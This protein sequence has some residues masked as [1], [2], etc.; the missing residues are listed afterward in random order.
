MTNTNRKVRIFSIRIS[1]GSCQGYGRIGIIVLLA[2]FPLLSI[3]GETHNEGETNAGRQ[4]SHPLTS[5][6]REAFLRSAAYSRA[7][8]GVALVVMRDGKIVFEDYTA[9]AKQPHNLYSGTKS[10]ACAVAVAAADDG[11]LDLDEPVSLT[12]Q[13]WESDPVLAAITIRQLLTLTSGVDAGIN[14]TVPSYRAALKTH[15]VLTPGTTFRYGPVPF[16]VFG[17]LM[18]RKL[19]HENESF[20]DYLKRRVLNPIH[21]RVS[22]WKIDPD[23]NPRLPGGAWL[24]ARE[25]ARYG[26]LLLNRG[27]WRGQQILDSDLLSECFRGT[28]ANPGYGISLWLPDRGGIALDGRSVRPVLPGIRII[29][30]EGIDGQRLYI[31]PERHLVIARQGLR[32]VAKGQVFEDGRFL[33]PIL[34]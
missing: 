14:G 10:F 21:L 19:A 18:R 15:S 31:I 3:P 28:T 1:P 30:A 8:R 7:H 13:E 4:T 29:K 11:I 20:L 5:K 32:P 26:Q 25:W 33:A 2:A 27:R 9:P 24:T 17:E 6:E 34:K 12:L 16:Q 23:G 22:Y